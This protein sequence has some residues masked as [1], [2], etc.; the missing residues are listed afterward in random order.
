MIV[1]ESDT[2][3]GVVTELN[4]AA[5][6]IGV[7]SLNSP[8]KSGETWKFVK[9]D[10]VSPNAD[11]DGKSRM[12]MASGDYPFAMTAF[13]VTTVK[14]DVTKTALIDAVLTGLQSSVAHN[15]AGV[16]YLDGGADYQSQVSRTGG[17]NCSPLVKGL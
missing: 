8:A 9:L 10:G 13:A 11:V 3:G 1:T 7:I 5:Y 6:G 2:G 14:K 4:K 16:A 17:N 15:F 12:A